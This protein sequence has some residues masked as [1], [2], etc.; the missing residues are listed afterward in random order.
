MKTNKQAKSLNQ[1][2]GHI[3]Q[4][5]TMLR[6]INNI[7][8]GKNKTKQCTLMLGEVSGHHHTISSGAVGF[9]DDETQLVDYVSVNEDNAALTHQEHSTIQM[10]KGNFEKLIQVEDTSQE[11]RRVAD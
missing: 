3:R 9:A 11:V 2:G 6:R 10:P 5:D 8:S 4:G 1:I 7:P